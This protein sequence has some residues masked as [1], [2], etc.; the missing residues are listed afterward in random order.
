MY[1]VYIL[2]S[3]AKPGHYTGHTKNLEVRLQAHNNDESRHTSN[4]CPWFLET[5]TSFR[6]EQKAKAFELNLKSHSGEPFPPNIF[7]PCSSYLYQ[8]RSYRGGTHYF[9]K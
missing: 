2:R 8:Q 9:L 1:Y 5:V 7:G 6:N 3:L 4:Y